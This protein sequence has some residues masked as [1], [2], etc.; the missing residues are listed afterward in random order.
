MHSNNQF[1][2]KESLQIYHQTLNYFTE[3]TIRIVCGKPNNHLTEDLFKELNILNLNSM[4]KLSLGKLM[5]W[6]Y[7]NTISISL[8][9]Q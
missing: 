4:F 3:K 5:Y 7:N 8:S 2:S 1:L 9:K 6:F